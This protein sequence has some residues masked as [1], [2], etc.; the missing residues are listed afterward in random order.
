MNLS[1]AAGFHS[2]IDI[3][4]ARSLFKLPSSPQRFGRCAPD[5]GGSF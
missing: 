5:D 1:V 4:T 2:H 3:A